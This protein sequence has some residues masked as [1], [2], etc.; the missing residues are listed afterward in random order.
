M[1]KEDKVITKLNGRNRKYYR[2]LGYDVDDKNEIMVNTNDLSKGSKA[3]ITAICEICGNE[4]EIFYNKY[5]QNYNRNDKGY[6][7]C[8]GCK[9]IETEKTCIEKYGVKSVSMLDSVKEKK[10][11]V[12]NEKYGGNA[13]MCSDDIKEKSKKTKENSKKK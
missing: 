10:K 8:F 3:R 6:Y 2:D 12:F 1:I 4:K 7:S 13:P 11:I 5:F 9:K